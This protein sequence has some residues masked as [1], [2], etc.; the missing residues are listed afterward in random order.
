M[1]LVCCGCMDIIMQRSGVILLKTFLSNKSL[2]SKKWPF[3]M[4]VTLTNKP[5]KSAIYIWQI[6]LKSGGTISILLCKRRPSRQQHAATAK[7]MRSPCRST[8]RHRTLRRLLGWPVQRTETS[9]SQ[10]GRRSRATSWCWTWASASLFFGN[11][12]VIMDLCPYLWYNRNIRRGVSK[13]D[14][15]TQ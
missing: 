3:C 13:A 10:P 6:F 9:I 14:N 5:A 11:E 8:S 7:R 12:S 2:L 4:Y 1:N 15:S